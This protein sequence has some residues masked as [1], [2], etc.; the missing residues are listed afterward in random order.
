MLTTEQYID[1]IKSKLPEGTEM[2]VSRNEK[3]YKYYEELMIRR[4]DLKLKWY[5]KNNSL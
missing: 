2:Y 3:T 4:P 5:K 1:Y